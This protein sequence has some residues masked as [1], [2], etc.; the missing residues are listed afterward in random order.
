[1]WKLAEVGFREEKSSARL[2]ADLKAAGFR[3]DK[4]VDGMPTAFIATAGSG[5]PVIALLAEYDALPGLSQAAV[6]EQQAVPGSAAGHA[7]G[8]NLLGAA[9]VSAAIALKEWLAKSGTPGTVRLY[10]TPAEEGGFAKAFLARDGLFRDVDVALSWHP[11]D[12]NSASQGQM[13]S[14][15]NGKFHFTGV[16]SHA[17]AAPER[18]RSALDGVEVMNVAVN[19]L[20]EHVPQEARIHYTITNGGDQPNIVPANAESFYY[21]RH[22]DPAVTLDIWDRIKNAAQGAA[23]ATGTKV[24]VEL[25]GG[26]YGTLPNYTLGKIADRYL[27]QTGGF[28]YSAQETAYAQ[29]ITASLPQ[30]GRESGGPETVADFVEGSRTPASSDVGDVSWVTPTLQISTATWVP[31]TPPHSWQ[32]ASASGTSI[33]VKGAL[34]AA[35]TLALTGAELFRS[36][37]EIAAAKA[38]FDKARGPNYH[39]R[40]MVGDQKPALDYT[41]K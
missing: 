27:R 20:R 19:Y 2:Q 18:G 11:S 14:V 9:S 7:C 36:P 17:A 12:R 40:A 1:M 3:I 31:G 39:Y 32:A 28:S 10:G 5:G 33:G 13:L 35:E 16:P 15:I 6:P 34:L 23:L 21:A 22:Y 41:R 24:S 26:S 37:E 29:K 25:I 8:H 30:G 38:E 4:G